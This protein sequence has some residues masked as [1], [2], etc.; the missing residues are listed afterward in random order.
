MASDL[1]LAFL[2]ALGARDLE[3]ARSMTASGFEMVF[4]GEARFTDLNDLL[5]WARPRYRSIA[6]SI[7]RVEEAPCGET[8][9]VYIS[10][11]LSGER[12]DGTSFAGIRFIDRFDVRAGRIIRQ[13][14]WNDLAERG[15]I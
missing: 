8:V 13:D 6:K 14:V 15:V 1:C 12:P 4:P 10:G 5:A 11:T 3:R 7:E 9:A 2:D